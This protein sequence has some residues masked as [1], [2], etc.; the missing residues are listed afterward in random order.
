VGI[1]ESTH[2]SALV[3]DDM[4]FFVMSWLSTAIGLST[5]KLKWSAIARTWCKIVGR[6]V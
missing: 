6:Y 4:N 5:W 3:D 1:R 2:F